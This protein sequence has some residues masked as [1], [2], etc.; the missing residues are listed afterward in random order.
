MRVAV[1]PGMLY[2]DHRELGG[3]GDVLE[4]GHEPALGWLVVVRG[5]HQQTIRT[6]VL[7]RLGQLE[8]LRGRVGPGAADQLAP[9]PDRVADRTEQL[10]FLLV[11]EGRRLAGG[12]RDDDRVGP[13]VDQVRGELAGAIEVDGMVLPERGH[14]RGD[15]GAEPSGHAG[16]LLPLRAAIG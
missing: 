4:V 16:P 15:Q 5:D 9:V 7:G 3:V 2:S 8:R 13:A 14:H 1:R 6:G 11:R 12:T 10:S